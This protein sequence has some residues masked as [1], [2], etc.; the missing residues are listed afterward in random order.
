MKKNELEMQIKKWMK[1]WQE[2]GLFRIGLL[3]VAGLL[4]LV[5]S[6]PAKE[7]QKEEGEAG[8]KSSTVFEETEELEKYVGRMEERL[9]NLLSK[10]E[11]MG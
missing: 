10:V 11:V 6:L 2:I 5:A 3:V 7:E 9:T 8:R 1:R 4:L